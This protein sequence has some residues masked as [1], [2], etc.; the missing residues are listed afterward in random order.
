[1]KF[2]K[3]ALCV[4]LTLLVV[5]CSKPKIDTSSDASMKSSIQEVRSSLPK[6]EQA[7]FDNALKVVGLS[8]I[9]MSDLLASGA[10]DSGVVESKF[11]SAL[12][13]KTGEQ[14]IAEADQ[15]VA[16]R[17][18]KERKQALA[19]IKTLE[20]EKIA[21]A[22][23]K[24]ELTKFKVIKSRFYVTKDGFMKQ[25]II[26]LTVVNDTSKAVS[27]A[28]FNGVIASPN[29]AV[30]WHQDDFNYSIPGGIEPGEKQT[31][32]LAPNP[33]SGWG[34]VDAPADAVF[35]ATVTRID[36]A[37][38]KAIFST[39]GF[40]KHDQKRLQELKKDYGLKQ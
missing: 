40:T 3:I 24:E 31:W 16:E 19:E 7:K 18:A 6:S 1:M 17:K 20:K 23:A 5:A 29:R 32:K 14:V 4:G 33:F 10:T 30:P 15:I 37:D 9:N 13:G 38:G 27:R 36:G 35:T 28:Y 22:H 21:A 11:K 25:P 2:F 34:N 26:E 12:N 8:Q 39:E